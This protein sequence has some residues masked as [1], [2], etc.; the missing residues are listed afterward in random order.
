[1]KRKDLIT[2]VFV[3]ILSGIV[4]LVISNMFFGGAGNKKASAPI[5]EEIEPTFPDVANDSA[6]NSFLNT[7][8]LDPTQP[9]QI[10]NN[11][12]TAPFNQ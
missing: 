12:N 11:Q 10:G 5:V 4:S 8:A 1:M 3:A 7:R 2:L 6:Y 9:V